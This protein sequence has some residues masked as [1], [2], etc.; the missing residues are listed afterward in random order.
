MAAKVLI[1]FSGGID[2]TTTI[3]LLQQQGYDCQAVYMITSDMGLHGR[4]DAERITRKLDVR[5]HVLDL[6]Q[7]F[8][9]LLLDYFC[10]QY[11]KGKT[12]NPC[13][14][15]NRTIK[16]GRLFETAR[17]LG[18]DTLATGHYANLIQ[19]ESG[20]ALYEA[21]SKAKDQ[22]YALAMV[23]RETY[24]HVQ[25]PMGS[26]TK[27]QARQIT[28][29]LRLGIDNKAESQ[30]ICFIPNDDYIAV[31]EDR[32]P[33]LIRTGPIVDTQGK[34]LGEHRGIHRYTIGQRRGLGVAMG[35]PYYV[36]KIDAVHNTVVL[37]LRDETLHAQLTGIQTNWLTEPPTAPFR[38]G[39]KIRY[40][41][42][43]LPAQVYAQGDRVGVSF[44]HPV[45]AITPGQLAVFYNGEHPNAR[46][47]GSAWID[48]E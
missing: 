14:Y 32:C 25:F 16:F 4:D 5:L 7:A 1:A 29:D 39:V 30:E 46:V 26:M 10:E 40:N 27:D 44:D 31:L 24:R 45:S 34:V 3:V 38:A 42:P 9:T 22:S 37:G 41:S 23:P 6:R 21:D 17:T 15:C 8:E 48:I 11:K 36:T 33:E 47:L 28:R 19:T 18:A 12:P 43:A 2:S 13:V 20:P 35:L